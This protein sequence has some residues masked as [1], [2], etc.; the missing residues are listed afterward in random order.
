MAAVTERLQV[1][2]IPEVVRPSLVRFDVVDIE[3]ETH[4]M[5]RGARLVRP[6]QDVEPQPTPADGVVPT[7]T[8]GV[9]AGEL[10]Q[11]APAADDE[12]RAARMRAGGQASRGHRHSV[13][14]CA[15]PTLPTTI[16]TDAR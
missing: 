15:M 13:R 12:G 14:A 1:R 7:A 3:L 10:V 9:R 6:G 2:G 8:V 4:A 16:C 11:G 5:T